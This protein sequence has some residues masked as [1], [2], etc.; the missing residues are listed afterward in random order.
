MH[1]ARRKIDDAE[2][3]VVQL[4]D[5]EL[6]SLKVDSEMIDT[7]ADRSERDLGFELERSPRRLGRGDNRQHDR[8][9]DEER[10]S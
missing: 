10:A 2:T 5:E 9:R 3:V 4:G 7:A 1:L 6:L 8:R